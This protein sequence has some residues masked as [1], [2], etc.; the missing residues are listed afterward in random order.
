MQAIVNGDFNGGQYSIDS[1]DLWASFGYVIESGSDD[2]IQLPKSKEVFSYDWKDQ[3]GR[4]YDLS[5]RFFDDKIGTLSGYI[6]ANDKDDFWTK[7]LALWDVLKSPGQR[8]LYSFELEQTFNV[9]Y[10]ESPNSKRFTS[11][12]DF[13]D[14]IA[15]KIDIQLQVMFME[16]VPPVVVPRPPIVNAGSDKII[17]LP[18][19]R[20]TINN[21]SVT[22]R[23]GATLT[24]LEW[25]F[26]SSVPSGLG[27]SINGANTITP[28]FYSLLTAGL[29]TFKLTATDSNGLSASDTMT[30]KVNPAGQSSGGFPYNLPLTLG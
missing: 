11:I 22:A 29:Y 30:V 9:F 1:F 23:G 20:V 19:D 13:P 14:K 24:S 2:L 3:N 12:Q 17:T 8:Q 7:Y 25:E 18:T 16:F 5:K 15:V 6:I 26:V 21:A 27:V 10:L 28:L 4:Q